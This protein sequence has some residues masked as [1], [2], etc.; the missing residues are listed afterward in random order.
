MSPFLLLLVLWQHPKLLL[1]PE[2]HWEKG[3]RRTQ[4]A[5]LD[6]RQKRPV[7]QMAVF[8]YLL[9]QPDQLCTRSHLSEDPLFSMPVGK[10]NPTELSWV[11]LGDAQMSPCCPHVIAVTPPC[12]AQGQAGAAARAG[13]ADPHLLLVLHR[14]TGV[15]T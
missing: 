14:A 13:V 3:S 2:E 11:L 12:S 1:D 4:P 6:P 15:V 7:L 5:P 9:S 8:Q 10:R